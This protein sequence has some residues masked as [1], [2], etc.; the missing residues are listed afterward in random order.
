MTSNA[1]CVWR[2]VNGQENIMLLSFWLLCLNLSLQK[3]NQCLFSWWPLC[4]PELC[5]SLP[6]CFHLILPTLTSSRLP[7]VFHLGTSGAQGLQLVSFLVCRSSSSAFCFHQWTALLHFCCVSKY[8]L[9]FLFLTAPMLLSAVRVCAG[10]Y[11]FHVHTP[12]QHLLLPCVRYCPSHILAMPVLTFFFFLLIS[13]PVSP[14]TI[15]SVY[16]PHLPSIMDVFNSDRKWGRKLL[17]FSPALS[18]SVEFMYRRVRGE[19]PCK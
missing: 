9:A 3:L 12:Q 8:L 19:N 16:V 5:W 7:L 11:V 6:S 14:P 13:H 15:L 18:L 2:G 1:I 17:Q 10:L 4:Y